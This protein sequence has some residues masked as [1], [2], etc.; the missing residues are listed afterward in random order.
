MGAGP[1]LL[2]SLIRFSSFENFLRILMC[3]S[4]A[5]PQYDHSFDKR[6]PRC[7]P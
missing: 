3:M 1:C 5:V 6:I 2:L 4:N 7:T